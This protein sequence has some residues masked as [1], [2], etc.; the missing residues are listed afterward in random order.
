MLAAVGR[1]AGGDRDT[2]PGAQPGAPVLGFARGHG[3][4]SAG[5]LAAEGLKKQ[6]CI[7][8]FVVLGERS[9]G[10]VAAARS[11]NNNALQH[12]PLRASRESGQ[13]SQRSGEQSPPWGFLA[14]F[15]TRVR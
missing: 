7:P 5:G 13:K 15:P 2:W 1:G 10:E 6:S 14:S 4:L 8:G 3:E 12:S 11:G 9:C